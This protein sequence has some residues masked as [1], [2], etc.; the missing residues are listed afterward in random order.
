M[1]NFRLYQDI[2]NDILLTIDV[3]HHKI[4][5]TST[6]GSQSPDGSGGIPQLSTPGMPLGFS[7]VFLLCSCSSSSPSIGDAIDAISCPSSICFNGA[8]SGKEAG[9]T[10]GLLTTLAMLV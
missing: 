5:L 9:R 6:S 8:G 2:V 1:F 7:N 10:A 3:D 4:I